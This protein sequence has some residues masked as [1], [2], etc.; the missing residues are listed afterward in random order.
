MTGDT[1]Y[2]GGKAG[3]SMTDGLTPGQLKTIR[4]LALVLPGAHYA[5]IRVRTGGE[6]RIYEAD[7]LKHLLAEVVSHEKI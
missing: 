6:N 5:D 7:W 2:Y 1:V 4:E 3:G